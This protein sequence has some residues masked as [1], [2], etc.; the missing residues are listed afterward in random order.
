MF[1]KDNKSGVGM[2][3]RNDGGLVIASCAKKLP[4]AYSGSEIET[5]AA[6]V[7]LS[8]ASEISIK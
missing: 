3:I 8:F 4:V 6:T 5:M 2:V 7:A 1:A